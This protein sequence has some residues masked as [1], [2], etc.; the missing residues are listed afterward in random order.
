MDNSSNNFKNLHRLIQKINCDE[1]LIYN[2][3]TQNKNDES[4]TKQQLANELVDMIWLALFGRTAKQL[5]KDW[6]L[7]DTDGIE[8]FLTVNEEIL[9]ECIAL[10][11]DALLKNKPEVG[12]KEAIKTVLQNFLAKHEIITR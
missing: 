6:N 8:D 1:E 12:A 7:K 11:T 3:I 9:L 2:S 4:R 10:S 5:R